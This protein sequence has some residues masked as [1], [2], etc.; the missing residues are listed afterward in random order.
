MWAAGIPSDGPLSWL[1]IEGFKS[2]ALPTRVAIRPLTLLAGA[3]SSGKSSLLQPLLLLKQTMES[4]FDPGGLLLSGNHVKFSRASE[5][6]SLSAVAADRGFGVGF[7]CGDAFSLRLRYTSR[8]DLSLVPSALD[9]EA[10]DLCLKLTDLSRSEETRRQLLPQQT[11]TGESE[12]AGPW[13][14]VAQGPLLVPVFE[15]EPGKNGTHY[16]RYG[17]IVAH[18][19]ARKLFELVQVLH[20]PA[21]RPPPERAY[22]KTG[23]SRPFRGTFDT[24]TA[25]LILAWQKTKDPRLAELAKALEALGL[26]WRIEAWQLDANSVELKVARQLKRGRGKSELVNIADVGFGTSQVLPVLVALIAAEPGEL[27]YLEQ[28]E[29]HLHPRAQSVLA[30]LLAQAASRGVRVIVETHSE[31]LLLGMLTCIVESRIRP[32]DVI[33]HWFQRNAAGVTKVTSREPDENGSFGDWP[34][35]FS[36]SQSEANTR[37]LD[38]LDARDAKR[39]SS[40]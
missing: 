9:V 17:D 16:A 14:A 39:G 31:L 2:L 34:E 8:G 19:L 15:P 21:W 40:A 33:L 29:V 6:I 30:D 28:P 20:V 25:S 12:A 35:D 5:M 13:R 36:L 22:P 23:T 7:G 38:A 1:E 3:N 32:E 26:T 4:S 11:P 24:Y 37:Y 27:V 18:S 10:G